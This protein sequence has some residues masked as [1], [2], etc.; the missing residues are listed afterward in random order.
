MDVYILLWI[1]QARTRGGERQQDAQDHPT[2]SLVGRGPLSKC[3]LLP[4]PVDA[5]TYPAHGF[6]IPGE[7]QTSTSTGPASIIPKPDLSNSTIS[8]IPIQHLTQEALLTT[9]LT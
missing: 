7:V 5:G 8:L 6:Y 9:S 3:A 1:L 4:T 2:M